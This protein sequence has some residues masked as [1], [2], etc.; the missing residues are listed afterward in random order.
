LLAVECADSV[1]IYV[2]AGR[3]FM[4]QVLRQQGFIEPYVH[5]CRSTR[6]DKRTELER[7]QR[8]ATNGKGVLFCSDFDLIDDDIRLFADVVVKIPKPSSNQLK[9]VFRHQGHILTPTEEAM[10]SS[11]TWTRLVLAFQ[12]DRPPANALRRLRE[13]AT[14]QLA[15][16]PHRPSKAPSLADLSGLGPVKEWGVDLAKDLSDFKAGRITWEEIDTGALV[17]GPPGTG[18]TLFAE[19]LARTCGVPIVSA[20]AARWQAAGYLN[21]L[22]AAMR[23]SFRE[24]QSKG[25]A[26][27]FIDEIDAIG[28]RAISDSGNADYK[29]QVINGLLEL[30][31]GFERREGVVVIGATNHPENI[32]PA[33]MRAGRLGRHFRIPL[34]DATTRRQIFS[35]H[36]GISVPD[37]Q[38]TH[39]S[40]STENMSGADI[41]QLVRDGRRAAR[42]KGEDFTYGHVAAVAKPLLTLPLEHMRVAAVHET[43]HALVGLILGMELKGIAITDTV[44]SEGVDTL[45]GAIFVPEK[46]PMKTKSF[47]LNLISM[48]LGGLAAE[49][50]VFGE[51]TEA[52]AGDASSDLGI[53]TSLATRLEACFGM[54]HTF[55]IEITHDSDLARLRSV[56]SRL[57]IAVGKLI[58][59]Q[60]RRAMAM[61]S[62]HR[63]VLLEVAEK[64]MKAKALSAVEVRAMIDS[65]CV[66]KDAFGADKRS[67]GG[68]PKFSTQDRC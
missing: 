67:A 13:T 47:Y 30:L 25:T 18:K 6:A 61:L 5:A 64:L 17:S 24:A 4:R 58:D 50:L 57:R 42:R 39:F 11:E 60:F 55:A 45:G 31:D 59:A 62:D 19:A 15:K 29:R 16:K 48:Y 2:E 32:D 44:L 43:G 63:V 34:P 53:S 20:S 23:E 21:D 9:A 38:K 35:F 54:G 41:R 65:H 51:F 52:V 40:R 8:A 26:L 37:V 7:F 56:D 22:L 33:I 66:S 12:P 3:L 14:R 28:S 27:L 49:T 10:V 46:F 36:A 68:E 1:D